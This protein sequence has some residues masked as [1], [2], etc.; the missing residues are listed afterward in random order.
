MN[1]GKCC[2]VWCKRETYRHL[3]DGH[4]GCLVA[5][6]VAGRA[7][8]VA[9]ESVVVANAPVELVANRHGKYRDLDRR[10]EYMRKLMARRRAER[11]AA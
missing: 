7:D 4:R 1:E 9:N 11:K 10:R 6:R 3:L 2:C 5:N 8:L